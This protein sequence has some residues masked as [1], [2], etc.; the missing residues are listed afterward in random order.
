MAYNNRGWAYDKK[1]DH[2]K[3]IAEY[4]E[5]IRL[6][7]KDAMAYNNRGWAYRKKGELDK[8]KQDFDQAEK[9]GSTPNSSMKSNS[10]DKT[11][12][13]GDSLRGI[14]GKPASL[15]GGFQQRIFRLLGGE[16][17]SSPKKLLK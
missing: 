11:Q 1:G 3:A 12:S 5:A 14:K 7:P 2:D 8:A 17:S 9:L 15:W 10:L 13:T 16:E 4:T 6:D